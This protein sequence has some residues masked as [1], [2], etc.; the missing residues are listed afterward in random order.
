MKGK[1]IWYPDDFEIELSSV[2]MANRYERDVFIPPFGN[3][4]LVGKM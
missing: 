3:N 2:F 1:W 4:I